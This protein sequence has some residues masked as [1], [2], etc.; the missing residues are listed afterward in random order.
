MPRFTFTF[1]LTRDKMQTVVQAR[2]CKK[3]ACLGSE[4]HLI[5]THNLKSDNRGLDWSPTRG[6]TGGERMGGGAEGKRTH[7]QGGCAI[8][9]EN[10]PTSPH[11]EFGCR[12]MDRRQKLQLVC[13]LLT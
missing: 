11:R 10:E 8:R 6:S 3:G 1:T 13:A 4:M 5:G 7:P 2:M 9:Q 12:T